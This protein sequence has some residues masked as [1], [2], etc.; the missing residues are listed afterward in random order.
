MHLLCTKSGKFAKDD[1][2]FGKTFIGSLNIALYSAKELA[3][4]DFVFVC[5]RSV[6]VCRGFSPAQFNLLETRTI[7]FSLCSDRMQRVGY[8]KMLEVACIL[9]K[10]FRLLIVLEVNFHTDQIGAAFFEKLESRNFLV[11]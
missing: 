8:A 9:S 2:Q 10:N 11:L 3:L 7:I 5:P 4:F 1:V 6:D